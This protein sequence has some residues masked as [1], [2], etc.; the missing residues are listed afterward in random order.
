MLEELFGV[1][2][3]DGLL[4]GLGVSGGRS[5]FFLEVEGVGGGGGRVRRWNI[6]YLF[7][8]R[9][10]CIFGVW[11]GVNVWERGVRWVG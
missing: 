5:W 2:F 11:V 8:V 7:L 10:I 4:G 1:F 6:V 9:D 3:R